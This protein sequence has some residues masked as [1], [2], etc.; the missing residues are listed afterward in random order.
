MV[1]P[2][3]LASLAHLSRYKDVARSSRFFAKINGGPASS[4]LTTLGLMMQCEAAEI[5]GK[6]FATFEVQPFSN[7]VKYP[8]QTVFGDMSLTFYC[9]TNKVLGI[10]SGL[11]E[12]RFF[13]KWMNSINAVT[14][15]NGLQNSFKFA[16]KDTYTSDIMVTHIDADGTP[17]YSVKFNQAYPLTMSPIPLAW[18]TENIMRL[19]M[20]FAYTTWEQQDLGIAFAGL[21]I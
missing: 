15:S 16:Y 3:I 8:Y 20:T 17:T 2:S 1:T 5:P 19:T 4:P 21:P 13:D 6:T 7:S 10:N 12:K 14:P 9:V 18:G 11:P